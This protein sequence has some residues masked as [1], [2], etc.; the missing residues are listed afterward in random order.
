MSIDLVEAEALSLT[1]ARQNVTDPRAQ[2]HWADATTFSAPAFD[3]IVMNPPFHT[4]RTADPSLGR[5]FIQAAARLLTPN[6]KLWMVANRHLPYEPTLND[7]FRT[8]DTL[9]GNSAFKVFYAHKPK[10]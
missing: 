6:G 7:C 1:C 2:F 4:G 8:V 5:S 10:R 9:G 3:G